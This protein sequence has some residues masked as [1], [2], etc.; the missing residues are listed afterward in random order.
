MQLDREDNYEL[1]HE[2]RLLLDEY[3]QEHGG[4]ERYTRT[5]K[6]DYMYFISIWVTIPNSYI[7]QR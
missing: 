7:F 1:T 4:I 6:N 2:L 3:N 5:L